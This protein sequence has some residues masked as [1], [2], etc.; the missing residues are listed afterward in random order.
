MTMRVID[1]APNEALA[2]KIAD[3]L[4]N[5]SSS[6]DPSQ[7]EPSLLDLDPEFLE[8]A[9]E[10]LAQLTQRLPAAKSAGMEE[11]PPLLDL[12]PRFLDKAAA[13]LREFIARTENRR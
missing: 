6:T 2:A 8:T 7:G 9:K 12:E 3:Q 1:I 11:T 10:M 4:E 5:A 13:M